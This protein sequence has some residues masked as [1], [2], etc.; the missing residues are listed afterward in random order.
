MPRPRRRPHPR[1]FAAAAAAVIVSS[2]LGTNTATAVISTPPIAAFSVAAPRAIVPSGLVA[3]AVVAHGNS[4]PLLQTVVDGVV[5]TDPMHERTRPANTGP[6]F[7]SIT[8]CSAPLPQGATAGSISGRAIP[9]T[10]PTRVDRLAM[11]GDSGCAINASEVQ[12]CASVDA[13]PLAKISASVARA[14]PDAIIF[15]GD[16]YYREVACPAAAASK[17]GSSPAPI[18]GMPFTDSAYGWIAEALL[19]MAPMFESAPLIP[20][21][22][23]HEACNRGGN[24]YFYLMDPR[25]DT[26]NTCAPAL[27]GSGLTAAA[28]VPTPT[29][30]ID[31]PVNATRTLRLAVVDSAGG[32]DFMVS[33]FAAVQRPSYERASML[34][35]ARPGRESWLLTHRPIFGYVST[36][37]ATPGVSFDP[38]ISADQ[39]A[40]SWGLLGHVDLVFSSHQHLAMAVQ[41]PGLPG[42]LVLGN[43]GTLADPSVGYPLATESLV[44]GAGRTYPSPS[45]AWV[46]ATFGFAIA[47]PNDEAG[48]W[49]LS[50]R[51]VDGTPFGRCGLKDR[52]LFCKTL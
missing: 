32:D 24:G 45:W 20:V 17:C 12:D 4:C 18:A 1:A 37:F 51:G 42:Q 39:T 47:T 13:W 10:M 30:A 34:T 11:L 52:Q 27:N 29:Y 19:P 35:R 3:R 2:I 36:V 6:A 21:R 8:V 33:P 14:K 5:R 22:G 9:S 41:I 49:S 48:S 43:G 16:F 31:L 50:M 46:E 38:W 25:P 40:A 15:N 28:T 44:A 7:E 26:A 23:N